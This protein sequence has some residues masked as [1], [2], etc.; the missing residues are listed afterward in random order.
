MQWSKGSFQQTVL[1]QVDRQTKAHELMLFTPFT[2]RD[3]KWVIG[4]NVKCKT[5]TFMAGN[6]REIVT[7]LGYGDDFFSSTPKAPF[8]KG[9]I[10]KPN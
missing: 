6:I 4:L 9:I 5:V 8:M 1:E 10:H 7:D 2:K 3:S